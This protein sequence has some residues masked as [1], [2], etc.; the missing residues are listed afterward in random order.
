LGLA[1]FS[2]ESGFFPSSVAALL[3][4][5]NVSFALSGFDV[6]IKPSVFFAAV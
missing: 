5:S 2:R 1:I 6:V 4:I 3:N